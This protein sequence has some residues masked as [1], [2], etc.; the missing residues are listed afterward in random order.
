M[1]VSPARNPRLFLFGALVAA[2]LMPALLG[3]IA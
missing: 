2:G 1:M 3:S